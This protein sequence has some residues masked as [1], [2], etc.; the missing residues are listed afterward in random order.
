MKDYLNAPIDSAALIFFRFFTGILLICELIN[1]IFLGKITQYTSPA[2]HFSYLFTPFIKPFPFWGV[3]IQYVLIFTTAFCVSLG[4]FYRISSIVLFISFTHLFLS[5][6]SE[7]INHAYLYCLMLFWLMVLPLGEKEVTKTHPRWM[8]WL[9][10]FHLGLAYFFA[11]VAKINSDWLSGTPMDLFLQQRENHPLRFIYLHPQAPLFFSWGGLI[12]DLFII[13][14]LINRSTRIPAFIAAAFF[15][16]SNVAMFGLASF[17]WYCLA[18]TSLFFSPS[19]SAKLWGFKK[20]LPVRETG[21]MTNFKLTQFGSFIMASYVTVHLLL[22]FRHLAYP[23]ST[24]WSEEGHQFSW[25]MML[26]TKNGAMTLVGEKEDGKRFIINPLQY[27][28]PRQVEKMKGYP[29]MII[30]FAQ[31]VAKEY[32]KKGEKIKVYCYS[33]ISLNN[34]PPLP[35]LDPEVNLVEVSRSLGPN[36]YILPGPDTKDRK[37]KGLADSMDNTQ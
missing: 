35:I 18:L 13:F 11:G 25:R 14:F 32:L 5:E 15:H 20:L 7:Y 22:P 21:R 37:T 26:R 19:W 33:Q 17:P 28:T 27:L 23:H 1:G 3:I 29:D 8:L 4:K 24:S 12:F 34:H 9:I 36:P 10:L 31:F 16:L 6:K 30:E 2:F